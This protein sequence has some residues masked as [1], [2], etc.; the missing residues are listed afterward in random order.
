M[1][2]LA[3]IVLLATLVFA[4]CSDDRIELRR[5]PLGPASYRVTVKATGQGTKSTEHREAT[6]S[7][8]PTASGASFTLQTASREVIQAQLQRRADGSLVLADVRGASV[9][10]PGQTELASLVGQLDPPLPDTRVRIGDQ[11][12]STRKISTGSLTATLQTN[13]RIVRYRRI[14]GID[15][16]SLEGVVRG[17]LQATSLTGVRTGAISGTTHIDWAVDAGRV[18]AADTQLVWTLDA[19]G[20]VVLSTIVRPV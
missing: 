3:A 16:A 6:M 10:N 11:W 1:K 20:R 2:R 19:G 8:A 17:Q 9:G 15:A 7:V 12:S 14:A 4:S 18:V 13:L 5:G